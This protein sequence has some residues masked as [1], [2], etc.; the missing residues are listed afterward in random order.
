LKA[1]EAGFLEE[2]AFTERLYHSSRKIIDCG[3]LEHGFAR[4]RCDHCKTDHLLAF[5]CKG[6]WFYPSC[7]QK[8]L[9]LFGSL[10]FI[11]L[12]SLGLVEKWYDEHGM[13]SSLVLDAR[14]ALELRSLEIDTERRFQAEL[15]QAYEAG[16]QEGAAE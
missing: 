2:G 15:I 9:Q 8:K 5:S 6:R 11:E 7:H 1:L 4:T 12:V 10:L 14:K 13:D 3:D 16:L